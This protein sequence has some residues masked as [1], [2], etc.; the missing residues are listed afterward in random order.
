M[1]FTQHIGAQLTIC[2]QA[3]VAN[4]CSSMSRQAL[5]NTMYLARFCSGV[6]FNQHAN[7]LTSLSRYP[8]TTVLVPWPHSFSQLVELQCLLAEHGPGTESGQIHCYMCC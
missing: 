2:Y 7:F 3:F 5:H 1:A 8:Y 4:K 6:M